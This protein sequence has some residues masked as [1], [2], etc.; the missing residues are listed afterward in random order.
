[1]RGELRR[2]TPGNKFV[3]FTINGIKCSLLICFDVRFPELYRKLYSMG[4][5]CVFQSFYNARQSGPSVHTDIMRQSMQCRAATNQFWVSMS[6][7]SGYYCPYPSCFI[8]P[9]GK[10]TGQLKFNRAGIMINKVDLKREFYD[11]MAGF[12]EMAIKGKLNSSPNK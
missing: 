3:R 6:N 9:N 8:E 10:I 11:P 2:F 12:R 1:M 7:S 4:V 5:R